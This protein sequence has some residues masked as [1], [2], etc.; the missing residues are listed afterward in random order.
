VGIIG[1]NKPAHF[2]NSVV[3]T[4][5]YPGKSRFLVKFDEKGEAQWAKTINDGPGPTKLNG[6]SPG[7]EGGVFCVGDD[8]GINT[9]DFGDSLSIETRSKEYMGFIIRYE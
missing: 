3:L 2:G 4:P 1:G 9:Y 8:L 6:V 5:G 7:P